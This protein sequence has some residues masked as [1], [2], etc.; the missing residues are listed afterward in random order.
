MKQYF[1]GFFTAICLTTSV[2]IFMGSQNKNLGDIVVNSISVQKDG[3]ESLWI[4]TGRNLGLITIKNADRLVATELGVDYKGR[5]FI[6]TNN[7]D[8]S[9][10]AF[11]GSSNDGGC[12]STNHTDGNQT[13]YLGTGKGGLGLLKTFNADGK[14]SVYLG[15]GHIKTHNIHEVMVGYF[16][17]NKDNDGIAFLKDR[18]NDVGWGASG[19]Q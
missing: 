5:G 12:I 6:K 11:I 14:M 3:E 4:G 15:D 13:S 1:T 9:G 18:Y 8:G 17:T 10:S 19:K 7:T 16:G 2:F